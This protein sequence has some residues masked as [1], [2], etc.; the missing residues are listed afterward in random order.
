MK[1]FISCGSV[2]IMALGLA[3]GLSLGMQ[4]VGAVDG[5]DPDAA[6]DP[7]IG[8]KLP[9]G[10]KATVFADGIGAV[11]H[12]AVTSDGIVYGALYQQVDGKGAIGLRDNDGDGV[13]DET[14]YFSDLE[15]SGIGLHG[16]YLYYGTNTEIFRFKLTAGTIA[17]KGDPV[18]VIDG[19]PNQ[20]GH[21]AKAMAFDNEGHIFVNIGGP[22]NI[23]GDSPNPCP[24]REIQASIWRFDANKTGQDHT[25]D[26]YKYASGIRNGMAISWNAGVEGL[27]FATHGRD[28]LFQL[29]PENYS[30]TDGAELPSEEFHRAV[31]G[32]DYGWPYTYWDWR[33]GE[34][35]VGPEYGG[36]G[37]TVVEAGKYQD[38]LVGFPGHW[39]PNGVTFYYG[40]AFPDGYEGGAF[41]AFHGSWNRAPEPQEGYKVVFQ[42]MKDG[43]PS[44]DWIIFADGFKGKDVLMSPGDADFRPTGLAVGPD[45]ALYIGADQGG[46]I[47]RITY[48]GN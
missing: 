18:S 13:A 43:V 14:A 9:A 42:P 24:Q 38:P 23:C 45:G 16:G 35:M 39:A 48:E 44:G 10:F 6:V 36:D 19:F 40:G 7:A 20:R 2:G 47:W 25:E 41:I 12:L 8:I 32:G 27:Y 33:K 31:E 11:R 22:S 17:P 30:R 26:G 15:G 46:R 29:F 4:T 1:R 37:K 28:R 5:A 34:R 3:L 21:A